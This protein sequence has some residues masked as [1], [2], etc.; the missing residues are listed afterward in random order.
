MTNTQTGCG[1]SPPHDP[2]PKP[3]AAGRIKIFWS[4]ATR[5]QHAPLYTITVKGYITWDKWCF[6]R[7]YW[8]FNVFFSN[9]DIFRGMRRDA[10]F[11]VDATGQNGR[12]IMPTPNVYH[13]D[14]LRRYSRNKGL[15]NT[16]WRTKRPPYLYAKSGHSYKFWHPLHSIPSIHYIHPI[17]A[18][19]GILNTKKECLTMT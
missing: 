10:I 3:T 8:A 5:P 19:H 7:S 12:A 18:R 17:T 9:A 4:L 15:F 1:F 11:V 16:K 14:S 6:S 2:Q 13:L